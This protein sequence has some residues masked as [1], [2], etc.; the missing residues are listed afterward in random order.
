MVEMRRRI[1]P[2]HDPGFRLRLQGGVLDGE[3]LD[4]E[5]MTSVERRLPLT[6][7]PHYQMGGEHDALRDH[8]PDV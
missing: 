3:T 2:A 8:A 1:R 7:I 4:E 6:Q 5:S